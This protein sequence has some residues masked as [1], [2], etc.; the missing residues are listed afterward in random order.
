MEKEKSK[1]L[2]IRISPEDKNA[3]MDWAS[4]NSINVSDLM[5]KLV[6]RYMGRTWEEKGGS[7]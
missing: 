6:F 1:A 5:R 3:I 2:V 4:K 7:E